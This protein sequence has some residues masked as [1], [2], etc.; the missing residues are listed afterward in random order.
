MGNMQLSQF[1][2]RL[3]TIFKTKKDWHNMIFLLNLALYQTKLIFV[4]IYID[5]SDKTKIVEHL[6]KI[7]FTTPVNWFMR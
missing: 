7:E 1:Q 5:K 2:G 6:V 4:N 3:K